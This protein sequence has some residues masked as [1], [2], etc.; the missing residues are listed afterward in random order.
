MW[1]PH[2]TENGEVT[3]SW[4]CLGILPSNG[5]PVSYHSMKGG[6]EEKNLAV[7]L[8]RY[9][10]M[11]CE[12]KFLPIHFSDMCMYSSHWPFSFPTGFF[13]FDQSLKCESNR[14]PLYI[15]DEKKLQNNHNIFFQILLLFAQL[16]GSKIKL[17]PVWRYHSIAVKSNL[18]WKTLHRFKT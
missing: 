17:S 7:L 5:W 13:E 2:K 14:V 12:W 15:M 4:V 18:L 6:G 9:I 3:Y 11:H 8:L 10:A 16:R 1:Y